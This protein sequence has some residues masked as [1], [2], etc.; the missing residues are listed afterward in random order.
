MKLVTSSGDSVDYPFKLQEFNITQI[1]I[2]SINEDQV[3]V[4]MHESVEYLPDGAHSSLQ[5]INL[6]ENGSLSELTVII[7]PAGGTTSSAC[8][9]KRLNTS[10]LFYSDISEWE[11]IT[12]GRYQYYLYMNSTSEYEISLF[13]EDFKG[14]AIYTIVV[15]DNA[16]FSSKQPLKYKFTVV[17][18]DPPNSVSIF[19]QVPMYILITAGEV[20]FSVTGLEFAYSQAPVSMKAMCQAAWLLTVAVGNF[21]VL[22]IAESSAFTDRA[23]ESF[24]FAILIGAVTLLFAVMSYFFKYVSS[25][26]REE[27]Q[28]DHKKD[29]STALIRDGDSITDRTYVEPEETNLGDET[30]VDHSESEF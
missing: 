17:E 11:N 25:Q 27:F 4:V 26:D 28:D 9:T 23:I 8:Q 30:E 10:E 29:E 20:M 16:N 18:L 6:V 7:E 24:F 14:G 13:D 2:T 19:L 15:S 5:V 3:D 21:V 1:Y 12:T 22:I